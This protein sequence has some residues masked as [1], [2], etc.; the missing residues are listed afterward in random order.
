MIRAAAAAAVAW[1]IGGAA[2][3]QPGFTPPLDSPTPI[4][5]PVTL[6]LL[7]GASVECTTSGV[8]TGVDLPPPPET[9]VVIAVEEAPN[10][11]RVR[12][13]DGF[14]MS[15]ISV[16]ITDAGEVSFD[17]SSR[18]PPGMVITEE[19]IEQAAQ[20]LPEIR[21]HN[22]TLGQDDPVLTGDEV[23]GLVA[24]MM[25]APM[26]GATMDASGAS[27]LTG[28][29]S[30]NG[31]RVIVFDTMIE[32]VETTEGI[33]MTLNGVDAYDAETALRVYASHVIRVEPPAGVSMPPIVIDQ[34]ITCALTP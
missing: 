33:R 8:I 20:I 23:A 12:A 32:V 2:V 30:F 15:D 21:I 5:S 17:D 31:R 3:A 34:T 29:S 11:V 22:R 26:A 1:M 18:L 28:E 27:V 14:G 16:L 4:A 9:S 10:G 7:P 19:D 13:R 25:G 24:A 6:S